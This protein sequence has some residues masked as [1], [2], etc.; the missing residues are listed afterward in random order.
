M[1]QTNRRDFFAKTSLF[2]LAALM[3]T[4]FLNGENLFAESKGKGIKIGLCTYLWGKD[5]DLP[6]LIKHCQAAG[7]TGIEL[8]CEH[9]HAVEPELGAKERAE[10]RKRFADAGMTLVGFGTNEDFHHP[11]LERVRQRLNRAKEYVQL[12]ADCGGFGVKVKPNDL[13]KNVEQSKTTAQIAA[14]L[15][16]LGRFAAELGQEIRLENHGGCAPIPIMKEIIDQ[17]TEKNVGLCW[18]CNAIDT[19]EPGFV[20]NFT[21][22][23]DRLASTVHVHEIPTDKYPYEDLIRLL[24]EIDYQGWLLL[25]CHRTPSDLVAQIVEQRQLFEKLLNG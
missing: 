1:F 10:V 4:N 11:D 15:N 19:R 16:E 22:V 13:P 17:V 25:E 21:S 18:N 8:R 5:D 12:S 23:Q 3:G 7:I 20:P 2:G 24:K 9:K 14:A 6:Q